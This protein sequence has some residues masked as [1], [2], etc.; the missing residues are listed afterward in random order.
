MRAATPVRDV[1]F[2]DAIGAGAPLTPRTAAKLRSAAQSRIEAA[3]KGPRKRPLQDT[4][5]DIGRSHIVQMRAAAATMSTAPHEQRC[6]PASRVH[7]A[8]LTAPKNLVRDTQRALSMAW[9]AVLG[10]LDPALLAAMR[11]EARAPRAAPHERQQWLRDVHDQAVRLNA[12]EAAFPHE[13][14]RRASEAPWLT[15]DMRFA[16][17][18][19]TTLR[20]AGDTSVDKSLPPADFSLND[21][22][23]LPP[24]PAP[25]ARPEAPPEVRPDAPPDAPRAEPM[26]EDAPEPRRSS[27]RRSTPAAATGALPEVRLGTPEAEEREWHAAPVSPT[28]PLAAFEQRAREQ[29]RDASLASW[30]ASTLQAAHVLKSMMH[31]ERTT[32]QTLAQRASRRAAAGFFF[33]ML[34]LGTK[35]CV[36]LEQAEPYG[37]VAIAAKPALYTSP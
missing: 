12:D 11:A 16:D 31:E 36:R 9:G 35:D 27:R 34:V 14:G 7:L 29:P 18:S 19:N 1:T 22:P 21:V 13:V 5:T 6:L 30:D 28:E 4:V 3:P 8:L 2:E 20:S 10:E 17:V 15:E 26:H 37:D 25:D 24:L 33:E 23:E 32:F